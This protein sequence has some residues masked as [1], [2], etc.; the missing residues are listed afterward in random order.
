M[1]PTF[2]Y[3]HLASLTH[4]ATAVAK[5][6]PLASVV[7]KWIHFATCICVINMFGLLYSILLFLCFVYNDYHHFQHILSIPDKQI[8][9]TIQLFI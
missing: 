4:F 3:P 1:G 5:W 2:C 7:A 9:T 6:I 8:E